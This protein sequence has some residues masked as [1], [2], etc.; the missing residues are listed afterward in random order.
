MLE[1]ATGI[2][3][4]SVGKPSPVMMRMARIELELETDETTM[5]GDTME[6][7]II[8]GVQLG[9]RTVLV[10]TGSTRLEDLRRYAYRPDLV[11]NSIADLASSEQLW[12]HGSAVAPV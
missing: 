10:L 7:D 1:T 12:Q 9:Y 8:G 5:I 2:K 11:V 6:T 4:F 3:A